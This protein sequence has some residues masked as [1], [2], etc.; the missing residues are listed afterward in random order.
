MIAGGQVEV[1]GNVES[2]PQPV[3]P[4]DIPNENMPEKA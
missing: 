2:I 4:V 1:I 3:L